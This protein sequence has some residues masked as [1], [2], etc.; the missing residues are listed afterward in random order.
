MINN[1][2]DIA[3]CGGGFGGI[4]AALAAAREGKKVILWAPT[5]RGNAGDPYQVGADEIAQL[6]QQLGDDYFL[7][8]KV[9]PHVENKM[10]LSS[11]DIPT[12]RLLPVTD[13]LITD[14][15]T[16][17]T[18]YLFFEKPFVLFAPDLAEYEEKRGF[19]VPYSSLS[20][21][22]VTESDRLHPVI[23]EA[24]EHMPLDRIRQLRQFHTSRCD[25]KATE[26]ILEKLG[27]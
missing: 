1:K 11:T 16:V 22:I 26:R 12:E 10:H 21:Y 15:S 5:F 17:L 7:I 9:H 14:Y 19:Y 18:E 13:L 23:L 3:V 8:Q 24:L 4:S 25:G 27:L 2:Y 6:K 20:P